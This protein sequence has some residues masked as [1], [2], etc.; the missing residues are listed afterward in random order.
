[1][2]FISKEGLKALDSYHYKS[3]GYTK[4]DNLMNPFWEWVDSL[5]PVT[6]APNVITFVGFVIMAAS[7]LLMLCYDQ[8]LTKPLPSWVYVVVA[9]AQFIYQTLDAVDGKH[10][11]KTKSS[12]PLGQLFDHGCDSFS[13]TFLILSVC[14]S[15]CMGPTNE[16]I[17]YFNLVQLAFFS[18]NWGEYHTGVLKTNLSNFGV[19]EGE[20]IIAGAVAMC[21]IFGPD[22]FDITTLQILSSTGLVNAS[23]IPSPLLWFLNIALKDIILK[24]LYVVIGSIISYYVVSTVLA[25]SN[26]VLAV[27]QFVPLIINMIATWLWSTL[28]VFQRHAAL[29]L[30]ISGL[31]YSLNTSKI[32]MCSLTHMKS[33]VFQMEYIVYLVGYFIAKNYQNET[34]DVWILSGL[35]L[36][37]TISA[38]FWAKGCIEQIASYLGIYCLSLEKRERKK[39]E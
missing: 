4:L 11:R 9:I 19:T 22:A 13:V 28:P 18:A 30:L 10:A 7:N 36:Y 35:A 1:M 27:S 15:I 2:G 8:S 29:V 34:A 17:F 20:L 24:T 37:M 25:S 32:I 31:I 12:S 38:V 16:V 39:I 5:I 6:I 21:G 14:Q 33:K 26:K 23:Q 3:G